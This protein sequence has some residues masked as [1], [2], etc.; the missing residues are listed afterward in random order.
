MP[1]VYI[2]NVLDLSVQLM[3]NGG[4]NKSF[5]FI[6]LFTVCIY[7]YIYIQYIVLAKNFGTLPESGRKWNTSVRKL[8]Q[9]QMFWYLHAYCFC[10]YCNH[11]QKK[12]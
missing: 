4:K 1:V 8:F 12:Q 3:T 9:L 5:A 10:L 2:E 6:T 7:M 11:T